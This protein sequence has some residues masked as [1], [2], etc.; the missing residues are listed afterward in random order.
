MEQR[1]APSTLDRPEFLCYNDMTMTVTINWYDFTV[2]EKVGRGYIV[3]VFLDQECF[4]H[5]RRL[6]SNRTRTI[7]D[8]KG[9]NGRLVDTIDH[10]WEVLL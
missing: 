8:R 6:P 5:W 3:H 2:A 9:A 4:V 7:V 10:R 1:Q